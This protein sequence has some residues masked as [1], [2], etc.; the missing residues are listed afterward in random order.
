MGEELIDV[1]FP[2]R[3]TF[4]SINIKVTSLFRNLATSLTDVCIDLVLISNAIDWFLRVLEIV[5]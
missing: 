2:H 4:C 5:L 1:D 3:R